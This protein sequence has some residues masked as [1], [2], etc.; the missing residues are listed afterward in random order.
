M[1]LLCIVAAM[2]LVV[3]HRPVVEA[4]GGLRSSLGF[5]AMVANGNMVAWLVVVV[6]KGP[7][8]A[9]IGGGY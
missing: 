2:V 4:V 6:A 5:V 8:F 1:W 9:P 3:D 7:T